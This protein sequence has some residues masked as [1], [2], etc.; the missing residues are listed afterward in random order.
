MGVL[1]EVMSAKLIFIETQVGR[2]GGRGIR[3]YKG[4]AE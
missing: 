3:S 2:G 1:E 4:M